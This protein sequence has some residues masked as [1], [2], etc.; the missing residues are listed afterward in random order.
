MRSLY[1]ILS[2]FMLS[3]ENTGAA[4]I[5]FSSA[6]FLHLSFLLCLHDSSEGLSFLGSYDLYYPEYSSLNST[7]PSVFTSP[8]CYILTFYFSEIFSLVFC[9]HFSRWFWWP[10]CVICWYIIFNIFQWDFFT[11]PLSHPQ[12]FELTY[13]GVHVTTVFPRHLGSKLWSC[14]WVLFHLPFPSFQSPR[15]FFVCFF[16]FFLHPKSG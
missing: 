14:L 1:S 10:L 12:L 9:L 11:S 13:I 15:F 3:L 2:S 5:A 6:L 16:F 8:P 4:F 7:S